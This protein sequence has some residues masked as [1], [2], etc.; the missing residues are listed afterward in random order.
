MSR[1]KSAKRKN[2]EFIKQVKER[3]KGKKI[4]HL[5][6]RVCE[7]TFSV[8]VNNE[9]IYTQEIR[10]NWICLICKNKGGLKCL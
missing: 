10:D 5:T 4:L 8:R 2:K 3:C 6:C 9:K 1:K 7:Q